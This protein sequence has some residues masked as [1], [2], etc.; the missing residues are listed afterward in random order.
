MFFLVLFFIALAITA[1]FLY[2]KAPSAIEKAILIGSA[3][4]GISIPIVI[5]NLPFGVINMGHFEYTWLEGI[6]LTDVEL[7]SGWYAL[8]PPI[9]SVILRVGALVVFLGILFF[10]VCKPKVSECKTKILVFSAL[11]VFALEIFASNFVW[12]VLPLLGFCVTIWFCKSKAWL[13]VTR[14]C[15]VWL[16]LA[17][18]IANILLYKLMGYGAFYYNYSVYGFCRGV[19]SA[20][21]LSLIMILV[22]KRNRETINQVKQQGSTIA[23]QLLLLKQQHENGQISDEDYANQKEQLIKTL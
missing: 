11:V 13:I 16:C 4:F 6:F 5:L 14:V 8:N 15:Y 22:S 2:H 10:L 19:F 21:C 23:Q 3:I 17:P 7:V 20:L 1:V 12:D 9:S 18:M